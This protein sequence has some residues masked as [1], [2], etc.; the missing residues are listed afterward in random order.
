MSHESDL[1]DL[2]VILEGISGEISLG[3]ERLKS[4]LDSTE[5]LKDMIATAKETNK[6]LAALHTRINGLY[7]KIAGASG[8]IVALVE[9]AFKLSK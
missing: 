4:K 9:L 7:I 2:R 3:E 1:A 8:V 5:Y 6:Q